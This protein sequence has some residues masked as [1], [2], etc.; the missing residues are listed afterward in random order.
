MKTGSWKKVAQRSEEI[1]WRCNFGKRFPTV[2]VLH[3]LQ[4]SESTAVYTVMAWKLGRAEHPS[5]G[6]PPLP[7]LVRHPHIS[8][9]IFFHLT[10][11]AEVFLQVLSGN[12]ECPETES[13]LHSQVTLQVTTTTVTEVPL[14]KS[15]S[16][17]NWDGTPSAGL[18]VVIN[19][20]ADMIHSS[21]QALVR[22]NSWTVDSA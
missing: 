22:R 14:L 16:V 7:A 11:P 18:G 12:R 13:T 4:H 2:N 5:C 3:T 20:P 9:W 21:L 19:T 6:L 15:E 10:H 1:L 17:I 8:H